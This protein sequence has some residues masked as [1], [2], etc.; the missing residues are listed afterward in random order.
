MGSLAAGP[1]KMAVTKKCLAQS[2]KSPQSN[3]TKKRTRRPSTAN[4]GPTNHDALTASAN[5]QRESGNYMGG[6]Y[7][8][9][10]IGSIPKR[11]ICTWS[12]ADARGVLDVSRCGNDRACQS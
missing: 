4:Q 5:A 1:A 11:E 2:N 9:N 8:T 6:F 10:I 7:G 12:I 3:A